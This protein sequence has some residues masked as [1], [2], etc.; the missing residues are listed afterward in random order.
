MAKSPFFKSINAFF[1]LQDQIANINGQVNR[2]LEGPLGIDFTIGMG[3]DVSRL[4]IFKP[5]KWILD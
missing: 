4:V 1:Q 5:R 2:R 3:R